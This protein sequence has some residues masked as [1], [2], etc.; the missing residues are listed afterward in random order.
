MFAS[1]QIDFPTTS[2]SSCSTCGS[3]DRDELHIT[4]DLANK[5]VELMHSYG[6]YGCEE[7]KDEKA[8]QY[9]AELLADLNAAEQPE[10]VASLNHM[11]NQIKALTGPADSEQEDYYLDIEVGV[12]DRSW[13]PLGEGV[14]HCNKTI[15]NA[16]YGRPFITI[17]GLIDVAKNKEE[18]TVQEYCY[19]TDEYNTIYTQDSLNL[20]F[21]PQ[22]IQV[23]NKPF[24]F[25]KS[26]E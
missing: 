11:L 10:N 21:L 20:E 1:Q 13:N 15:D 4:F 2:T 12:T 8:E 14:C 24:H 17:R 6:C 18:I 3:Y 22:E 26:Y 5:T 16:E 19:H 9:I 25:E 23:N 7:L